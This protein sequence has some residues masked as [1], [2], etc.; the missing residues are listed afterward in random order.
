M[1]EHSNICE[2]KLDSFLQ[3]VTHDESGQLKKA[4]GTYQELDQKE[5]IE[6]LSCHEIRT[7]KT[8]IEYQMHP[9]LSRALRTYLNC[10]LHFRFYRFSL[11]N[12]DW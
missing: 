6:I 5:L 3:Y 2:K 10:S 8:K 1:V 9:H 4:S 7:A 12:R 11:D